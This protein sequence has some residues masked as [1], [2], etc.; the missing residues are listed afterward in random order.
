MHRQTHGHYWVHNQLPFDGQWLTTK[1]I[2]ALITLLVATEDWVQNKFLH[3]TQCEQTYLADDRLWIQIKTK[4]RML[5]FCGIHGQ[6]QETT[7]VWSYLPNGGQSVS[8]FSHAVGG[9]RL[10]A[11]RKTTKMMDWQHHWMVWFVTLLLKLS[12]QWTT[13]PDKTL[14]TVNWVWAGLHGLPWTWADGWMNGTFAS[15]TYSTCS[16]ISPFIEVFN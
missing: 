10:Q 15:E 4:Q 13:T 16:L 3:I 11:Q 7:A 14:L 5:M 8:E 12:Q 6:S 9:W 1:S 2:K